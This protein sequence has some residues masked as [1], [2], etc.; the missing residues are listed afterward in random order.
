MEERRKQLY[1]NL[2]NSGKTYVN[3]SL[4]GTEDQFMSAISSPEKA[5]EFYDNLRKYEIFSV[6]EIGTRD[7]F[8]NSIAPDFSNADNT[9]KQD[10]IFSEEYL[11]Q[12]AEPSNDFLS[13]M[14]NPLETPFSQ[15][16]DETISGKQ[17]VEIPYLD[18]WGKV[19][20][21]GQE[22]EKRKEAEK[23][24]RQ[25]IDNET[26]RIQDEINKL[27]K[28]P[29]IR[30]AMSQ[31]I[32]RRSS[33]PLSYSMMS[34][35]EDT[36]MT[37]QE[38][39]LNLKT[40]ASLISDAKKTANASKNKSGFW[41]GVGDSLISEEAVSLG[42]SS[43]ENT[44]RIMP[45]LDKVEK[46]GIQSLTPSENTLLEAASVKS[47]SDMI[48]ESGLSTLYNVGSATGTSIPYML[49]FVITH[50]PASAIAKPVM[51]KLT[52]YVTKRFGEAA[53]K[54]AAARAISTLPKVGTKTALKT[55]N[56]LTKNGV[57]ALE[58]GATGAL[59]PIIQP[60]MYNDILE[61]RMGQVDADINPQTGKVQY[62]GQTGEK[63]WGKSIGEGFTAGAIE[64]LAEM[65]G[66]AIMKTLGVPVKALSKVSPKSR[67]FINIISEKPLLR[68]FN[69]VREDI[70]KTTGVHSIP[71]EALEEFVGQTANALTVGDQ[72]LEDIYTWENAWM[73]LASV[74]PL[75]IGMGSASGV[76]AQATK[77]KVVRDYNRASQKLSE[78]YSPD[79]VEYI[80]SRVGGSP[81]QQAM[82]IRQY[83]DRAREAKNEEERRNIANE[84]R[85]VMDYAAA[86][87][88]Y[89]A[90]IG[91]IEARVANEVSALSEQIRNDINPDMNAT[92]YI[93]YDGQ[94][95]RVTSGN[96]VFDE[97][98]DI[99]DSKSDDTITI[100][101]QDGT[102]QMVSPDKFKVTGYRSFDDQI[103]EATQN[104]ENT[105]LSQEDTDV[106]G[107]DPVLDE[108]LYI[109]TDNGP[110][111]VKVTRAD[112]GGFEGIQIDESGKEITEII[113]G[114]ETPVSIPF[115]K[116]QII[117]P[118][119]PTIETENNTVAE[120]A[121]P[122]QAGDVINVT[123][124][125]NPVTF[126]SESNGD[127]IVGLL[128]NAGNPIINTEG[129]QV[130][131]P[132]K[133]EQI[134]RTTSQL[135]NNTETALSRI[136]TDENGNPIYE[137]AE[138]PDLAWDAIIE[139]TDGDEAMA[140]AVAD[141]MVADKESELKKLEKSKSKG[142]ITVAEKIAAEKERKSLIDA[143]KK[144]LSIWQEIAGTANKRRINAESERSRQSEEQAKDMRAEQ[145]RIKD[146]QGEAAR[147]EREALNGVTDI[148][149]DTHQDARARGTENSSGQILTDDIQE[150]KY[151]YQNNNYGYTIE[152]RYHKKN[153]KYIYA[154]K[155]TE[156]MPRERFIELK[157]RVKNFG[158]YY[159]SF[160]KGGFIFDNETDAKKFAEAV[161]DQ[162]GELLEDSAPVTLSETRKFT[163]PTIEK[164]EQETPQSKQEETNTSNNPSGN[165]LVTD[166][167]YEELKKRMR[168]KLGQLNVGIDP[169]IL[170]IGTEM[171][172][173]HIEKGARKFAEYA[174]AMIAD[175][176]DVVRPYL[177]SFY[178]GARDL[179]EVVDSGMAN[180]MTPYDDVRTF[181]ITNFDK[182]HTD[183]FATVKNAV[184][185][186]KIARQAV[187]AKKE[188]ISKRN[189]ERRKEN[190]QTTA[191]TEIIASQ[192]D[193][194]ASQAESD[195]EA[196]T[197]ERQI[198][199]IANNID[200][201][202]E[203]VNEQ[204]AL[205][206]YYEAEFDDKDFNEAY[207]YMRNAEK[208]AVKDAN[209]L[210]KRLVKDL[211]I[212]PELLVDKKGK[213]IK[214]FAR[215]NIAPAGGD[216][217]ITLPLLNGRELKVYISLEPTSA[218]RGEDYIH[219]RR[220]DNLYIEH[221]M[222][223]VENPDA[224]GYER[225]GNNQWIRTDADYEY[226]LRLL[227]YEARDFLPKAESQESIIGEKTKSN[228]PKSFNGYKVGDKVFYTPSKRSG[229][230][231]EAVIHDFENEAEHRP[232]LD[233]GLA[234]I[235]YEI[236]DWG[237]IKPVIQKETIEKSSK[238]PK[239]SV[240][241]QK[242]ADL[243]DSNNADAQRRFSE[244]VRTDM[245]SALD[246]GEKPYRSILD[247]RKRASDL[248]MDVDKDGRTDIL[249]QE[250]VEDGLVRAAREVAEQHGRDSRET[251]DLICKLYDMQPT[252]AARSSNR[253]KMQQYSTPLP[254][255]WNA[256]RFA[257]SGKQDGKVLEPTAG[258]GM[259][260]FS[261][262]AHQVHVNELDETRLDNL[263]EQGFG[264][265]TQ[266][267][268]TEP[269][270]GGQ[271]Y[272]VVIAN[273]PFGKREASE[274][275]GK[276]IPGLDPQITLNA[277]SSM[278]DDGKAAII[279]G[280]NME[281]GNNGGL[282]SMKPFF[283]YLYD[284]YN[285]KGVVDM[286]G[287]LYAK[288]GTTYPTRMIL[289]DGRR[290]DE[291]RA[292]TA[293]Y[294][295][296]ESKAIR[297]AE[298]FNELYYIID[299]VLNS[300]EKTNGTE[301]LRS[302]QGQLLSVDNQSSGNTDGT[303]H[304]KQSRTND[305]AGRRQ[306]GT[307]HS[308]ENN[309]GGSQQVLSREHRENTGN[310]EARRG[311]DRN[312]KGGSRGIPEPD[313]QRVGTVGVSTNRVELNQ[314]Q[315][316]RDLTEEK[317]S[318][319]P[320][321]SA[322][323][324]NSVAPAAMV[325]AM[326]RVLSQI[327]EENGS[328]DEFVRKELGYDTIEEA[329]QALAAEQMDSVAMAIYQ[330]KKGQALIIGDQTGVGKGRQM[331][332]LIR[333]AVKR[334]EKPVF[335]T[336][337]ADLFSDIYRDLVDIG[338]G[339]LV[340]FIFN[341]DGA[342]VDSN[343]NTV[344]KPL[345][346]KE[347]AKVFSTG[348]L[349]D[350]Y[351][352]A[353][354]TYSQVN[355]GDA[356]SQ[357]EMEEAAKKN[358]TRVKKSKSLK[359]GKPTPKA[360]FL[361][362][363]AENNYLF[364]DESHTAA[365]SSNT[366]A[367]LQSIL[368]TAKAV[369]F[370][371]ATFAKRPNTMPLYAIRTAMSQANVDP[372]KL[373]SIIEKGGIT[374]QEIMSRELTN[375]GQMVRRERDMSDVVTD[376][377]TIDGPETVKRARDNY[378]RTIAAFNAIIKFQE[379]YVKPM[380]DAMDKEI[381]V[382][383][384]TAGIK[385]G[386]DKMG[387]ENVPFASKT[388]NYTKQLMLAL[389]VDAIANEVDAEIKAGRHPV[390]AL[391]STMESSIK[392][393]SAGEIIEEP[394]FSASLLK[395]LDTVMQY[396]I[397]DQNGKEQ[398]ARY[399][400]KQLGEAGEKAY[401]ELQDFIREST[402]DI[403]ISPL[404][405]IIERL[406]EMGYKVGE[407]T[408][409]NMYVERDDDGRVVVRRRTDKDK[410]RMQREFNNGELDVLILN[411][412]ASTGISLHASEK[413]SDQRQRTMI[414][415]QPLSD[416]NDY[417]QMIGRIDR[418]GQVHRGYY[419]NLGLPV[420]AEN[421][422]LMMLSTKLKS[423]N[424]NT[425]T[426][427]DSESNDVE[428]PDLLNKYG[429]QVVVEYLR[430]NPE[431][432][433]KM[434]NPLKSG[435]GGGRVQTSELDEYNTQEDDAR[436]ITGYVAL[437]NTKEQEEFYDDV[438]RRYNELIKYLNDTG[439][440]DLK[441]TVMPLHAKTLEKR[442]SSEGIDPTGANPFAKNSY[443]EQVE[444]DVLRKPMK[445]DEI[446]KTIKQVC[447]GQ[448][449]EDYLRQIIATIEEEDKTRIAAEEVRYERSK[450]RAKEDIAKQTE[451]INRQQKRTA[452]EKRSAIAEYTKE[453]N[454]K[455]ESKHNDN[456][457]RLNT[458][459]N[460]LKQRLYMF[461]VG[462]S[463][464]MP[465]NLESM[466]FDFSTPAI[467]CGYKTKDS[468][469][470]ASTTLAVFA[471][472]DSRRRME[473]KLS[474][475][476]ALRSIYKITSDNWDA[477]QSTTL[478][479]WDNQIP[480]G[481]RKIGFIM[482][483]NI[484]QAIADTQDEHGNYPGQLIS[485]TDIDGNVHDG[486]LM[487]DKW[488]KS[489][490]KTSGAPIISRLKQIK[491][492]MPI[493]SHDGKVEITG[494]SWAKVF[495]LTVPK[496]KKDGA[497]YFENKVL[498]RS[499]NGSNFYPYR[500]K[501]RADIPAE[502]IEDVVKELSKLGVK[503][504]DETKDDDVLYR[505]DDTMYRIREEAAPQNIG[506]EGKWRYDTEA[507]LQIPK[508]EKINEIK[509]LSDI[510]NTEVEIYEI[511]ADL[512]ANIREKA[513]GEISGYYMP[514]NDKVAIVLDANASIGDIQAT[515][516]HE[517][518]GHKGIR[519]LFG[520]RTDE[521]LDKV[522]ESMDANVRAEYM[523][524]FNSERL[525]AEEYLSELAEYNPETSGIKKII[526][527]IRDFFREILGIDLKLSD[528]DIVYILSKSR[529]RLQNSR[530][531]SENRPLN[532]S[533]SPNG[534]S[535]LIEINRIFNERLSELTE[536]NSDN[537]VLDLG[538][539][540]EILL[541]AGIEDKPMKLYGNK[542]IKKM[543]KHGFKLEELRN[544]PEAVANPIAVFEG[545]VPNSHAILTE[546]KTNG[547][548]ILATIS[549]GK[550]S[551]IDFNIIT[552]AYGKD[553]GNIQ[554][555]INEGKG[556][557]FNKEKALDYLRIPAPIAGA[558]DSQGL[559]D[560]ANIV[561]E[562]ENPTIPNK[563]EAVEK[564]IQQETEE[565]LYRLKSPVKVDVS[566]D[567]AI[568]AA[569]KISGA[570]YLQ[571]VI[572]KDIYRNIS[573]NTLNRNAIQAVGY[574]RK[575][576]RY[577]D[578]RKMENVYKGLF[579]NMNDLHNLQKTIIDTYGS[580]DD[581]LNAYYAENA[582]F[583]RAQ[584]R[585]NRFQVEYEQ[586]LINTLAKIRKKFNNDDFM[587][588][589]YPSVRTIIDRQ[590]VITDREIKKAQND[591]KIKDDRQALFA[592]IQLAEK[593]DYAGQTGTY[594]EILAHEYP[595]FKFPAN[596]ET[597]TYD[598]VKDFAKE[599]NLISMEDFVE[600]SENI[601][602]N[603]LVNEFWN[604]IRK[605]SQYKLYNDYQ[606]GM[607]SRDMFEELTYG[608]TMKELAKK[609]LDAGEIKQEQY[610]LVLN[611]FNRPEALLSRGIIT[612]DQY[613]S[614]K[615]RYE[616]YLPL[617]G[618]SDV[619]ADDINEYNNKK[620]KN[621]SALKA[622]EGHENVARDPLPQLLQ[623][624]YGSIMSQEQNRWRNTL[625]NM[626]RK[627]PMPDLYHIQTEYFTPI[628]N[629]KGNIIEYVP[630][631]KIVNDKLIFVPTDEEL[632]AKTAIRKRKGLDLDI[633][634]NKRQSLEHAVT[635][636]EN[637]DY[638]TVYFTDPRI[639]QSINNLNVAKSYGWF[640]DS[641]M[642]WG[643][644]INRRMAKLMTTYSPEFVIS[645]IVRD[646]Q[647]ASANLM[648]KEGL[649]YTRTFESY[650]FNPELGAAIRRRLNGKKGDTEIDKYV[651]EFF[652]YGG[653]T[654]YNML[655]GYEQK[656]KELYKEI[657]KAN[658][659]GNNAILVGSK[660]VDWA[661]EN[662]DMLTK[663]IELRARIATYIT[664]RKHAKR[665]I[666]RSI[667]DAKEVTVNFDKRGSWA[668]GF[669]F[670]QLFWNA[671]RQSN[672]MQIQM[673]KTH[674]IKWAIVKSVNTAIGFAETVL[675]W[676]LLGDDDRD[677]YVEK[678]F[679]ITPYTRYS[680][681]CFL[682]NDELVAIPVPPAFTP[683]RTLGVCMAEMVL[684]G[685]DPGFDPTALVIDVANA[686][687]SEWLPDFVVDPIFDIANDKDFAVSTV[688]PQQIRPFAEIYD[689]RNFFGSPIYNDNINEFNPAYQRI[690]NGT[691]PTYVN[692]A[693]FLNNWSGGDEVKKGEINLNPAMLEHLVESYAYG[694]GKFCE[695][696]VT[697]SRGKAESSKDIP[698]LGRFW[699]GD[700]KYYLNR[701]EKN[702]YHK[703]LD[704]AKEYKYLR[705]GYSAKGD[706]E[707]LNE[708]LRE[709]ELYEPILM[710]QPMIQEVQSLL[711]KDPDNEELKNEY[712]N[713][714][715]QINNI[716]EEYY[717][718]K[719]NQ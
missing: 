342:M 233:T 504:K 251:F 218:E 44:L 84:Y 235:I 553:G 118:D 641:I 349:P 666:S 385:K 356:V 301:I 404:D 568:E 211:G 234:P 617:K 542:V 646:Y 699:R 382:M 585:S 612:K 34:R 605:I 433:E 74:A 217:T 566:G 107:P 523:E 40:A 674:P 526:A 333:W 229:K 120:D 601:L 414:I 438:V 324:L 71:G 190:E 408:G 539:P 623:D 136:P 336:Q 128:D 255:S 636:L 27:Q 663:Q 405:A 421:R 632:K 168:A 418:T 315:K 469:I 246:T 397:T 627:Y 716:S 88:N 688:L 353:I 520:N 443:V 426:S 679:S 76:M 587:M 183:P 390:I 578:K 75:S 325:E 479:N 611:T 583:S 691:G 464:L 659:E 459:S 157:K 470:T 32:S 121:R 456:M 275:D 184:S 322:F 54:K 534:E 506:E 693:Q 238:T 224:S 399:S 201:Q 471:T 49:Q 226:M 609:R 359:E 708:V 20:K 225:Y 24:Y 91:G 703:L 711:K 565:T 295:P 524:R 56:A 522:F 573:Y 87:N 327:E 698:V 413:F 158:G 614:L 228:E 96:I 629:E 5:G 430:D 512:P 167:R 589:Y 309:S 173:Y 446:S 106:Y 182:D 482:T 189:T 527:I 439:N 109:N 402:S 202:I 155:F 577:F 425:T 222:Y 59:M 478:E 624:V 648:I 362:A 502:N 239:K 694:L 554:K 215:A 130:Q 305:E 569:E 400:P 19:K 30:R 179:P 188:I 10:N 370:A 278:K 135:G 511:Q 15:Y 485:Y 671:G 351:D 139:Q 317:L 687:A 654:A 498:L 124:F 451:K 258:N 28:D 551:D 715:E 392:D 344:H 517:I 16:I 293:V 203:K 197:D 465:D 491:D 90:Y 538:N 489:M 453:T 532:E 389:K 428:A 292:Q 514:G 645:N 192:A 563:N 494:S 415:A 366:G 685:G 656:R 477:A 204:L 580:I 319:R 43:I 48:Y 7:Q 701:D 267:D 46:E 312:T 108:A 347:M 488:N 357:K 718:K 495:Y 592:A 213:R 31:D 127:A 496:T 219:S 310:G 544:L 590:K 253:I 431:I 373:I 434:G 285:V 525:A 361:R 340:P 480:T 185:E 503:V 273:P 535:N 667:W 475:P 374:L 369:T 132:V 12:V 615:P 552:S 487:P 455:V 452:E 644:R 540:S 338:S 588:K 467:F 162:S 60:S 680:N 288:Q 314:E 388:Y 582:S 159:S 365:G 163:D 35:S 570:Q 564:R 686:G 266:Q 186:Q 432:Y 55:A 378:D 335:I 175:L 594:K 368:R 26:D 281:Y 695:K 33:S 412:S 313:I 115:S 287:K 483:G 210:A 123:G 675:P 350:E 257:M 304:S 348:E 316:K 181:D 647:E 637:G 536:Q 256:A 458:N 558:Q 241:S 328:I 110:V 39:Y 164:Q 376:W 17:K 334:G 407:L 372:D 461:E 193:A 68:S 704:Q 607:I 37:S 689:N 481:T 207:G 447:K 191:N 635:F 493:I 187:E 371:S 484:L 307:E 621:I 655:P 379:D 677:K 628:R 604:N 199:E 147:I 303:G 521:F 599:N 4:I 678:Y 302:Q 444:M 244:A 170:A 633:E 331:A 129:K 161:L 47:L 450:E 507:K 169:E 706:E 195:I 220:G 308:T 174:K 154:V 606:T 571:R 242:I 6:K 240:S 630:Y 140:Q 232:V 505:S 626:L 113:N 394:T 83:Y 598:E 462:R 395:G 250:L 618:T 676:L 208:K 300:K 21:A 620:V 165:R 660:V 417:M 560:I 67:E 572:D 337:K 264:R 457:V 707:K 639:A 279:I 440:N 149:N 53:I 95:A 468:K 212:T 276:M 556:L 559:F 409:R 36:E 330:M 673:I 299:E 602:G 575:K 86:V 134:I 692:I 528:N 683:S 401:Y 221:I 298:S 294:P 103:N 672:R 460:M 284:H 176:G 557:Y 79:L 702:T 291:E 500:G 596:F 476:E 14:A 448:R 13:K 57:A 416:I 541:S 597:M 126:V 345:S 323:S 245:L 248:G 410:K 490:L 101:L 89:D 282:K 533:Y 719:F 138:T 332:A 320:H 231:E 172:V 383:A 355:T 269:F 550:G 508:E 178:N 422:F 70:A 429:S 9:K 104:I 94:M 137:Q 466:V 209:S 492:Y 66:G 622:V 329:H 473:I 150:N 321:N 145:E 45:I 518:V 97:N 543:K 643:G 387:V 100:E 640:L 664:S 363:I 712:D 18:S 343:G 515:M 98:G 435:Q 396:T 143:A 529:E 625:L 249:L 593:K 166:E 419:I 619:E 160:G 105:I 442:V 318:Y 662:I 436:K 427:Q 102:K 141:G 306:Q 205:L 398:H 354:L 112:Y 696:F 681:Y 277:L 531:L 516:L 472:L 634:I 2:I 180:D 548:N 29:G 375:A 631:V 1:N 510:L 669:G 125:Q 41:K 661:S 237:D 81:E 700:I 243:F 236:A 555:W 62:K 642:K 131:V 545:S 449:P 501:L 152:I 99:N 513:N 51:K 25:S 82:I 65:S 562:F 73:T 499:I 116:D 177:K 684:R 584:D 420:P 346:S 133:S 579:D 384:E 289:I 710:I 652:K 271:Q 259:L 261:V 567:S 697:T 270:E 424:A 227:K 52:G 216:V 297:K 682:V 713:I 280:G 530:N 146:E 603:D 441:I 709:A 391:E 111:S 380:V 546:L 151:H 144:Q 595:E 670:Y 613:N 326:D 445:A 230:P 286:D 22:Y 153:S 406:H 247:L 665:S 403:F 119:N 574:G 42:L 93:D 69:R 586:P 156:Q 171:A 352:F 3:E 649:K 717:N 265:V 561:K 23:L 268:A 117:R 339:D 148:I 581:S 114:I 377:K 600:R 283:T 78:A 206:G 50:A 11:E 668:K 653:E 341:S 198:N 77:K 576:L 63:S 591:P 122:L 272:D 411:K 274:Y 547:E 296:V 651:D 537:M 714:I 194:I 638:V 657:K 474:Q 290:S 364:L 437:L 58:A 200:T 549:I 61:R 360:T 381:A 423:L 454:E 358:G 393:Y 658:K 650:Y 80:K 610:E 509:R 142:G 254:M 616:Y 92:V 64:N 690:Y 705:D 8:I 263:R 196:A 497:V 85:L 311:A 223:R 519:G 262:P 252:I 608:V 260:V 367:Y 214:N 463:Y 486:I 386:T 38:D 72:K